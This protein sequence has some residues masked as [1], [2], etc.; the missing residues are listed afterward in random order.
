MVYVG[1]SE[2]QLTPGANIIHYPVYYYSG[3]N[4]IQLSPEAAVSYTRGTYTYNGQAMITLT[5]KAS[6][7]YNVYL[8]ENKIIITPLNIPIINLKEG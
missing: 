8:V 3:D 5:P 6:R 4:A 2:I 1:D 7:F